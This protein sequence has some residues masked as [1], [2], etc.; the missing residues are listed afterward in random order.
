MIWCGSV[1]G[2]GNSTDTGLAMSGEAKVML[3]DAEVGRDAI[4]TAERRLLSTH[5]AACAAW[6]SSGEPGTTFWRFETGTC[7]FKYMATG[8]RVTSV[9]QLCTVSDGAR[10]Q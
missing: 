4:E 1:I 7:S 3:Q 6:F 10:H 8:E 9:L 5:G 2:C